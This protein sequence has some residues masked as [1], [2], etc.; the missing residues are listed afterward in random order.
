MEARIQAEGWIVGHIKN[1]WTKTFL[2]YC[3]IH[4][5]VNGAYLDSHMI[6]EILL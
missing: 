3:N 6:C 1:Q 2:L 4:T 5:V